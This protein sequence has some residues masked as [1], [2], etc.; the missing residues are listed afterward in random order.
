MLFV[1]VS[2][3]FVLTCTAIAMTPGPAFSVIVDQALRSG[4]IAGVAAVLGNTSGLVVWATASG[5]GL[6]ALIRA[7]EAAF[8]ALKVAG[9]IYLCWLGIKALR[10]SRTAQVEQPTSVA[11]RKVRLAAFRVGLVTNL[12]NPKTAV[13]YLALLPQFLPRH[14]NVAADTALLA[15]VHIAI[16]ATWYVLVVL[17]VD[18]V[19]RTLARPRVK[20]KIEQLSGLV[21]VGLGVRMLTLSRAVH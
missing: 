21:M 3:A 15:S 2:L 6:T 8:I 16:S 9:A 5:L 19:R 20:A 4:R 12:A 17:G 10:H 14:G 13:L 7:S 1:V 18:V 11:G